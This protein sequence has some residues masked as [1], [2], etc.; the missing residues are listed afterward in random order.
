[1]SILKLVSRISILSIAGLVL[2]LSALVQAEEKKIAIPFYDAWLNSPHANFEGD[3]FTNWNDD[4]AVPERCAACHSTTGHLDYLGADGSTFR[5]VDSPAPVEEGVQCTACHNRV[6]GNL[7]EITFPSGMVVERWEDDARCMDCHQ[8]RASGKS[9]SDMIAKANV[10]DDQISADVKFINVH[11][12]QAAATRFGSEAGG[13]YEYDTL[14]YDGFHYH[15]DFATQCNDCHNPHTTE[16][17]VSLCTECHDDVT[18]ADD[19]A[20]IRESLGDFD[21]DG[22]E[23]EGVKGEIEGLHAVLYTAIVDYSREVTGTQVLYDAGRYPYFFADNNQ[24]GVRD[25]GDAA[26]ESW[27]PRLAR[28]AYNYQ[29]A[30]KDHGAFAHNARYVLQLLNDSVQDLG[31]QVS[32]PNTSRPE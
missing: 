4:G 2:T 30:A 13:G 11:Y 7:E 6:A 26:Y 15:D 29:F 32:V 16:V 10:A 24:N 3:A 1:M 23:D 25:E 8:G 12:S 20:F 28:A 22:D 17:K 14:E 19:F 31:T 27:T 5:K 18:S 21:A 9:V